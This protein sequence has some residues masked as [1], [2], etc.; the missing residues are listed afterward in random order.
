MARIKLQGQPG[1]MAC[2]VTDVPA[3]PGERFTLGYPEAIGDVAGPFWYGS[4]KPKWEERPD[5]VW[6]STGEQPGQLSYVMTLSPGEDAVTAR[7]QLTNLSPRTWAQGMAFNCV[8][9]SGAPSLRDHDCER[10]W[11][12]GEGRFQ[13]LVEVPRVC[14]PRPAIQLYSVEGAPPGRELPFVANFAATPEAV[15]EPWMAIV[16][17]DGRK[18]VAT[19]SKP[20]LFLFQNREYSCI[21]CGAGFG[22]LKPGQTAEAVNKVYFVAST[23]EAWHRRMTAELR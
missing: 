12:R 16:S 10:H 8:Q 15:L 21:H 20:G 23:L 13:R 4:I 18:L 6:V 14:G 3:F 9:C 5:G 11:V 19:V 22:E 7:F 2:A 17:C 1:A